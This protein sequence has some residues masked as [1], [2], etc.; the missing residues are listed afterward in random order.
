MT[1]HIRLPWLQIRQIN[2]LTCYNVQFFRVLHKVVKII[3]YAS[4]VAMELE[5]KMIVLHNIIPCLSEPN[6]QTLQNHIEILLKCYANDLIRFPAPTFSITAVEQ[7][8]FFQ[9]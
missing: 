9:I 6:N 8:Y 2:Q 1:T 4:E 3:Q 7:G 5:S